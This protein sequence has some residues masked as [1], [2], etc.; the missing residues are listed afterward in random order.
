MYATI[1][2]KVVT[3]GEVMVRFAPRENYRFEQVCPGAMDLTF[4]GAESSVA[5]SVAMFGGAAR[6]VTALPQ[7]AVA[8]AFLRQMRGFKV[9]VDY[10][11]RRDQG[12]F[13][14]YYVETGANQR[15]SRVIYDREYSA[16]S[17][18]PGEAYDWNAIFTDAQ[19]LHVSGI[20]LAIS[21]N[22]A[23]AAILAATKAQEA[24]VTV[25]CDLNFRKNLWR[26]R[27]GTD[28]QALAREVMPEFLEQVNVVI[29]NEEDASDVLDIHAGETDVHAGSLDISRYPG[30]ARQIA[31]RFSKVRSVAIT[32]RESI[33]ATHNNWGAMLYDVAS[34]SPAF[35]P[36][37]AEQYTPY[38]I[39]NIVDRVGGG[40][41][42]AAGLIYAMSCGEFSKAQE[43]VDFA[44]AA[45]CLAHSIKGDF[46]YN[47]R[48]EV[49]T[50]MS[51]NASGRV[52][53]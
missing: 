12:R 2:K 17:Q 36:M 25:S 28:A 37:S 47:S 14:V 18:C 3:F 22:A 24:G 8:E 11:L 6:F 52:Q 51:G 26:W 9:D 45:S 32:L 21:E 48:A 15:P 50:L 42:F 44:V 49:E 34:D 5:A 19:W 27:P 41:S 46:N 30:V 39:R 4:G 31:K 35:A 13:G 23:R 7:H 1:M 29:G 20:T 16:V 10:V 43:Q 53:R 33:S 38:E 40:D